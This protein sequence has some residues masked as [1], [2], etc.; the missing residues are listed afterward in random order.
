MAT[1]VV[2]YGEYVKQQSN[3]V[4]PRHWPRSV[5]TRSVAWAFASVAVIVLS[6]WFDSGSVSR[7]SRGGV[8]LATDFRGRF[9]VA[10]WVTDQNPRGDLSYPIRWH[11]DCTFYIF[12]CEWHQARACTAEQMH[13][14]TANATDWCCRVLRGEGG[15]FDERVYSWEVELYLAFVLVACIVFDFRKPPPTDGRLPYT[16]GFLLASAVASVSFFAKT[17]VGR[18]RPSYYAQQYWALHSTT[19]GARDTLD[20]ALKSFPSGHS[21]WMLCATLYLTVLVWVHYTTITPRILSLKISL[22]GL[23]VA[24]TRIEDYRHHPSDV[25]AGALWGAFASAFAVQFVVWPSVKSK[26]QSK[27]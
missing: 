3:A 10:S 2:V 15:V 4:G 7:Q 9:G 19:T 26:M 23:Y 16:I 12:G 25:L 8:P 13:V 27:V 1:K 18:P 20:D 22:W 5:L 24:V 14:C 17:A 11:S 6:V 21:T